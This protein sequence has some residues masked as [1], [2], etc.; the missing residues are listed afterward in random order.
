MFGDIV[1]VTPSSKVVGDMAIFMTSNGLTESD[2]MEQGATLAFPESVHDLFKGS[3]GQTEGGFPEKLSKL[4]LKREQPFTVRPNDHLDAIDFDKEFIEFQNKFSEEC[5]M[6]DFLSYMM[7]PK[8]YEDFYQHHEE[9]GNTSVLPTSAFFYGLKQR[10]EIAVELGQGK[11]IIIRM[12]Y[13]SPPDSGG[14][15]TVTFDLN[16]QTRSI[17][18]QDD[19]VKSTKKINRKA[20]GDN[21]VGAPIL[22]RLSSIMVTEA[23]SIEKD[24]PLFVIEAM[25]MESTIAAPFGGVIKKIH[26]EE[27]EILEQGDLVIEFES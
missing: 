16:G 20:D 27:G 1:K 14:I 22:G 23:Q 6:L 4:I 11:V 21:E 15:R 7:Y 8:V 25:K 17:T 2:V 19:S 9:Y 3:L 12:L 10:E 18:I 13:C 5:S 24:T 26:L